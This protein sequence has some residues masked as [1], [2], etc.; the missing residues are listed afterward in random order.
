MSRTL[1]VGEADT[2][3]AAAAPTDHLR[4]LHLVRFAFAAAWAVAFALSASTLGA[5][6]V[7]LLVLYPAFDAA[8]TAVERRASSSRLLVLN[9]A[10]SLLAAVGLAVAAASGAPSVLR[11]WGA[12]RSPRVRSSW[13]WRCGAA[14]S[15]AAGRSS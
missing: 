9:V 13:S 3:G 10:L 1:L 2:A 5:A 8:A 7:T 12:G 6:S 14:D 15:A 11:V 4:R